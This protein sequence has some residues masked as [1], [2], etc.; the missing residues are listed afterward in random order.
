LSVLDLLANNHHSVIIAEVIRHAQRLRD[1]LIV[2]R[3]CGITISMD[4]KD[5]AS[6]IT[7]S[8]VDKFEC[9]LGFPWSISWDGNTINE[10]H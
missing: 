3:E 2:M 8:T 9:D 6:R 1:Q 4:P 10:D 5:R 7:T